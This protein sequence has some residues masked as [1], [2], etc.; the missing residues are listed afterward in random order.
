MAGLP[1]LLRGDA[2]D[3]LVL[4]LYA[5]AWER[6]TSERV[7]LLQRAVAADP[8]DS[9]GWNDLGTALGRAAR[10]EPE[11]SARLRVLE[12]ARDAFARAA[13]LRPGWDRALNNW[14]LS[15]SLLAEHTGPERAELLREACERFNDAIRHR[16]DSYEAH[17]A[18]AGTLLLLHR[19]VTSAEA[20]ACLA[21][22]KAHCVEANRIAPGSADYN[23]ACAEALLGEHEAAEAHLLAALDARPALTGQALSDPD[24]AP[25]FGARPALRAR[26]AAQPAGSSVTPPPPPTA[27]P[28][29]PARPR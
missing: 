10:E 16:P 25:L 21:E 3:A 18:L 15:L 1:S 17:G 24:L 22:A 4:R 6:P 9:A 27:T 12:A 14:G 8:G 26:L 29:R 23:L 20:A 5:Q 13:R 28:T 19:E 7:E 11:P 2:G